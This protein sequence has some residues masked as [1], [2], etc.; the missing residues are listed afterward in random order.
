MNASGERL[1]LDGIGFKCVIGVTERERRRKQTI[2]VN[3]SLKLD[4]GRVGVSDSIH[5][6]VDYRAVA[7]RV[8]RAGE[9]SRFRLVEAL[10][11]HLSRTILDEFPSVQAVRVEVEKPR[12]LKTARRVRAVVVAERG[13]SA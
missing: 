2:V 6:T 4:F 9:Q 12:A 7:R 8:I 13:K 10:A 3:L 5:D 11:T 1:C